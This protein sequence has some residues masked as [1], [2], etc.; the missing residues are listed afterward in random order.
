MTSIRRSP[1]YALCL[2][3]GA[4]LFGVAGLAHPVLVGDGAAQLVT[5]AHTGAW[6]TIH[7]ALLFGLPLML[8]GLAGL[9]LRHQ[10]TPGAG[11]ARAGL[12]LATL[13]CAAWMVNI[14][15]MVGAGW[16]LA[17]TFADAEPG[18]TAT[19]A[20]F[21]YDMVHPFG[22]AAERLATF[23]MGLAFYLFGWTIWNGRVYPRWLAWGS[24]AAGAAC[25]AIALI[26]NETSVALFYGQGA[27]VA[28]MA[29]A[30]LV[31]LVEKAPNG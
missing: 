4:L 27:L 7:W 12:I 20:V 3:C 10:D 11:P 29:T 23:T 2:V 25:L 21:L 16:R 1:F 24:F 15:F 30:G 31:M 18:L 5:I 6:R 17:H 13:G 14:L 9:A 19:H 28:W 22:L 8:A 26:A